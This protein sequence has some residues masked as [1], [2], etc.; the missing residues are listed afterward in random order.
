MTDRW[1][2]RLRQA[3]D[4]PPRSG[5]GDE[6]HDQLRREWN[7]PSVLDSPVTA[8]G[9]RRWVL[10][11]AAVI[12]VALV[13]GIAVVAGRSEQTTV[14]SP[15]STPAPQTTTPVATTE[16][17][18]ETTTNTSSPAT[19][20]PVSTSPPSTPSATPVE[21]PAGVVAVERDDVFVQHRNG[22]L[23]LHPG[24]LGTSPSEPVRLVDIADP[25]PG[26]EGPGP[27][28]IEHVAG[29]VGGS[30]IYSD[31]CEP[32][33]GNVL[34]ASG[35][36]SPRQLV[37]NGYTPK[38]SPDQT[39]LA[40]ANSYS[41]AVATPAAGLLQ[42]VALNQSPD[43]SIN[44][45][46][47]SWVNNDTLVVLFF[48]DNGYAVQKY[49]SD[50]LEVIGAPQPLGV[51]FDPTTSF[52]VAFAGTGADD[53]IVVAIETADNVVLRA[54]DP[55]ALTELPAARRELPAGTRS[56][57]VASDGVGLLWIQDETL[58]HQPADGQP[59][60]LGTGYLGAWYADNSPLE[61]AGSSTAPNQGA[62]G[63]P[64][65]LLLNSYIEGYE[66]DFAV[67]EPIGQFRFVRYRSDQP[68]S[69]AIELIVRG[70]SDDF[71]D[72]LRDLN[73]QTWSVNG[74]TVYDDN[75][76]VGCV[77]D[78]CSVGLQWDDNT[79]VSVTWTARPG[80]QLGAEHSI[81]R[82]V[83]MVSDLD[84]TVPEA[85][86]PAVTPF[87]PTIS[88]H[89]VLVAGPDGVVAFDGWEQEPLVLTTT[90]AIKAIGLPDGRVLVQTGYSVDPSGLFIVDP[91]DAG[92]N[93]PLPYWPIAIPADG[94]VS[95]DVE[96]AATI[97]GVPTLL[98]QVKNQDDGALELASVDA[99][100]EDRR[101]VAT[102]PDASLGYFPKGFLD[103]DLRDFE[104][105]PAIGGV[106]YDGFEPVAFFA[107]LDG[108]R[109]SFFEQSVLGQDT[110]AVAF[111]PSG[112]LV[113][114]DVGG[115]L[116]IRDQ[117]G[118]Q[119]V[120]VEIQDARL[121]DEIDASLEIEPRLL[122]TLPVTGSVWIQSADTQW[123]EVGID[124]IE[125]NRITGTNLTTTNS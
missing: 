73:R 48:D 95:I 40:A 45:W 35:V 119:F 99:T 49:A 37:F 102:F 5:F 117:V 66:L 12:G 77:P 90:P 83:D 44:V 64:T 98:L 106:F 42:S 50:T 74:R 76:G 7:N 13:G 20:T 2:N 33:A 72:P 36:D 10:A 63:G 19:T 31:C 91:T 39:R 75:E 70:V 101:V 32:V 58:W 122:R 108:Q 80:T 1:I 56:V 81:D 87:G 6:L 3:G 14:I 62:I 71:L 11:A 30:V 113:S 107:D 92:Q 16:R 110:R 41:L 34:A 38:L 18:T 114:K 25:E 24:L 52:G 84:E 89:G 4:A 47:V 59:T 109:S 61:A 115:P 116:T 124:G 43:G 120:E 86:R 111:D 21:F 85:F 67:T 46:D 57:R 60:I 29:V 125:R 88:S 79:N 94:T 121:S 68:D 93:E 69:P 53:E 118:D 27:N 17:S 97:N 54:L 104:S 28:Q 15:T 78:Y 55:N 26:G 51:A 22:D 65:P 103:V 123:I 23:W 96:D 112:F 105:L 82:L 8:R 100:S 9:T